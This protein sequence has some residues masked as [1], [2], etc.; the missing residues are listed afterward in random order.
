MYVLLGPRRQPGFDMS[1]LAT[2]G[3]DLVG[4]KPVEKLEPLN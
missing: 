2:G 4:A 3:A 1:D